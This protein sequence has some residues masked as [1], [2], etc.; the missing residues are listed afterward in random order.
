MACKQLRSAPSDMTVR[1]SN[2]NAKAAGS[3][4][5]FAYF[6]QASSACCNELS[7]SAAAGCCVSPPG[8]SGCCRWTLGWSAT[9]TATASLSLQHPRG[10]RV[11]QLT[12]S[13]QLGTKQPPQEKHVKHLRPTTAQGCLVTWRSTILSLSRNASIP[14]APEV[15]RAID[16]AAK[17]C[18]LRHP[19]HEV[20]QADG[21]NRC[22]A[23]T[24]RQQAADGDGRHDEAGQ[25]DAAHACS[26]SQLESP[27]ATS[28][29]CRHTS[30]HG[31]DVMAC[32]GM[33]SQ[34]QGFQ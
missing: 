28:A 11:A 1:Y 2:A 23:A 7:C 12:S 15:R 22:L 9:A 4:G 6:R 24:K 31:R 30:W 21:R 27:V 5:C 29:H 3:T 34:R 17:Q 18:D 13:H 26:K 25:V 14:A 10:Q 19:D 32:H 16:A 20:P 8:W 33:A